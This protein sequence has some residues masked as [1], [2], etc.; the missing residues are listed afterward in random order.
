MV[1]SVLVMMLALSSMLA[2]SC[3][4]F[5]VDLEFKHPDAALAFLFLAIMVNLTNL[6]VYCYFG[7]LSSLSYEQ[8]AYSLY[9]FNWQRLPVKLQ[10]YL[11]L[12]IGN[13]HRPIFYHGFGF[14]ILNLETFTKLLKTV[15]S[16]Y[17]MLVTIT[18]D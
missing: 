4:I 12:M 11:V 14:F 13:M 17:M 2:L 9:E 15:V 6:F 7:K 1:K 10:K 5:Q 16:Y 8:M 3:L 18:T